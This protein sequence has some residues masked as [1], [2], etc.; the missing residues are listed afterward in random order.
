MARGYGQTLTKPPANREP[1][2]LASVAWRVLSLTS[3][4]IV[5]TLAAPF[6]AVWWAV[7]L[8]RRLRRKL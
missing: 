8:S 4:A 3:D 5:L 2:P 7:V 6:F 1:G